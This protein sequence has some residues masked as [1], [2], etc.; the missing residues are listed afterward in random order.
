M[1][2]LAAAADTVS[3]GEAWTFWILGSIAVIGALGMVIA[4]NAV[5]SAL[6]LVVTMLCLGFSTW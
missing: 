6:W 5:H 1:T 2:T 4:R 3:T